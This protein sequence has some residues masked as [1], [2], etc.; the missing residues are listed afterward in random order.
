MKSKK[1]YPILMYKLSAKIKKIPLSEI[2]FDS[3]N[4]KTHS[5]TKFLHTHSLYDIPAENLFTIVF[6]YAPV[7]RKQT[8]YKHTRTFYVKSTHFLRKSVRPE[9][10]F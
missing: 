9:N 10:I 1:V 8:K 6:F 4:K 2:G 3:S 7:E 5:F